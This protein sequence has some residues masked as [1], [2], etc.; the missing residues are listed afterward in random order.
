MEGPPED[1]PGAFP[2]GTVLFD[3]TPAEGH[4]HPQERVPAAWER[5]LARKHADPAMFGSLFV[6][7]PET[8][9]WVLRS[10]SKAHCTLDSS[11]RTAEQQHRQLSAV[12]SALN[13][14]G[15]LHTRLTVCSS[16]PQYLSLLADQLQGVGQ[17]IKEL[18]VC[19]LGEPTP[20]AVQARTTFIAGVSS[21]LPNVNLLWADSISTLPPSPHLPSLR[22][23]GVSMPADQVDLPFLRSAAP[24][25]A[26][27]HAFSCEMQ[28][29]RH[30]YTPVACQVLFETPGVYT[31]L[32]AIRLP[33]V[34]DDEL[35]GEYR[36]ASAS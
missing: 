8:R 11:Q 24:Y 36:H 4:E 5:V 10:A 31:A 1:T 20:I 6:A 35:L 16:D 18:A 13:T 17:G 33:A 25:L 34:L 3:G 19:C 22:R 32:K 23:L 27:I 21:V 15:D 7:S 2:L 30:G 29:G 12:G 26:R 9:E 28:P 14:R